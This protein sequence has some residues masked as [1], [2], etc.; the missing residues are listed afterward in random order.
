MSA[1]QVGTLFKVQGML[2]LLRKYQNEK[3]TIGHLYIGDTKLCDVL[4]PPVGVPHPCINSGTYEIKY[5]YSKMYGCNMPF[6]QDVKG[7]SGIMIHTGNIPSE[8]KGCLLV[9]R[10]KVVGAL[11]ESRK[12]FDSLND[13][14][15]SLMILTGKVTITIKDK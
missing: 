13:I 8:T 7:R 9:G 15:R 12:T 4:E 11:I 5:Q 14:I 1:L 2:T 10:N 3:Y 6:L